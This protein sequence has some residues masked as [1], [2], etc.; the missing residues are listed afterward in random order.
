MYVTDVVSKGK[1]GKAYHSVLLRES[2]RIGKK[3][4]S[5]TIANLSSLS[6]SAIAGI[7]NALQGKSVR[8][9]PN[10]QAHAI[11]SMLGLKIRR[12][13]DCAWK[14]LDITV[15]EGLRELEKVCVMN[16]VEKESGKTI[17]RIL[18]EPNPFQA[19]L[20]EALEIKLP[21]DI[22][23]AKVEVGTRKKIKPAP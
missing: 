6:S 22:P 14:D 16:L 15:E 3:V 8:Q 5:R 19:K 12:Y 21:K 1:N 13:L 2:V 9:E 17:D 23:E 4:C 11:V 10:T 7:K 18:P 20:L